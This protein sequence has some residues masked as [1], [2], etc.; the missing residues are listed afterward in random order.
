[1]RG[2]VEVYY[3]AWLVTYPSKQHGI[4][5]NDVESYFAHRHSPEKLAARADKIRNL[6]KNERSLVAK[7]GDLIVG[8]S[9]IILHPRR[10]QLQT[11]YVHPHYHRMGIGTTLW[12]EGRKHF[13]PQNRSVVWVATY[14]EKAINFY[15]HLGFKKTRRRVPAALFFASGAAI[16][17]LEMAMKG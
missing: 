7:S 3:R 15:R 16:P 10:N 12:E 14:N 11:M 2:I 5:V 1:V 4:T 17:E 6:P 9:R 8:A 13:N